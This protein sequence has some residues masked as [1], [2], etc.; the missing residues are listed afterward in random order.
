VTSRLVHA[1]LALSASRAFRL[2]T[3]FGP[4]HGVFGNAQD[5][6]ELEDGREARLGLPVF[7]LYGKTRMPS[8]RMLEGLDALLFDL[9]DVGSRYYT[10]IY[11]MLNAMQACAR[12]RLPL[13]VLD[14]PNP[15]GGLRLDGNLLDPG[16]RSF[17]GLHPLAA[18]HAMTVGELALMF[19]AELG[20]AL[21]LRVVRMRGLRREMH[22]EDTGLPWVPPSPNMPSLDTA[23]VYPGA[24]LVEGTNLSEGRGTTRPF[25]IVGAPWLDPWRLAGALE[26]ERLPGVRFR[27]LFF[28]PT[29]QKHAGT[30]CGGVQVH[31]GDRRRFP[32]FLAYLLLIAH[33]RRQAPARFAWRKPPYEYETR[34]LPIDILCGSPRER[35]AIERGRSLRA[36]APE[37]RRELARFR[38]RRA[39]FL[40]Y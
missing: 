1:A 29:F 31:V 30:R 10:F 16:Y 20:L 22:F 9:Q 24:C 34:K 27:P 23:F 14:R 36:L 38:R 40:L 28:T 6:V 3:L 5:L 15:L 12:A 32:A 4:E 21:D 33:A 18:R 7:S 11:T 39:R 19:R 37:W 17:V 26:A 25:E 35:L 2:V 8:P 13:V